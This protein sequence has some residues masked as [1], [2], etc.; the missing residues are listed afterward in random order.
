MRC[1]AI[2]A[3]SLRFNQP[4]VDVLVSCAGNTVLLMFVAWLLAG[5]VGFALGMVAGT[6]QG[7]VVDRV[8][9]AV[10]LVLASAPAF[11]FGLVIL[12]VFSGW[13]GWLPSGLSAPAGGGGRRC[14]RR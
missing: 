4:V 11:W 2:W 9:K 12:T 1:A 10:M 7:R 13:L 3:V 6:C 8:I 14:S 5:L